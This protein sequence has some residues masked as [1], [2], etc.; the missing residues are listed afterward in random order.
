MKLIKAGFIVFISLIT[1]VACAST[2]NITIP[3]EIKQSP[4]IYVEGNMDQLLLSKKEQLQNIN[5]FKQQYFYP[6]TDKA[7]Q[8]LFC[9]V[10]GIGATCSSTKDLEVGTIAYY[11]NKRGYNQYYLPHIS[12]WLDSIAINM[13]L[14]NFPNIS[15]SSSLGCKGIMVNNAQVR[16]LPTNTP[17]YNDFT[18]AG[19][20]FPF[21]YIQLSDMWLGTPVQAVQM[22][23]DEKWI[24]VKGQGILGWVPSKTFAFVGSK[25]IRKWESSNFVVPIVQKQEIYINKQ[26]MITLYVGSMLP[27]KENYLIVPYK[28]INSTAKGK[29]V[30]LHGLSTE[31]WPL[32]PTPRDFSLQISALLNMPYGWG[33][34]GF[35][36]D[37]SGLMRRLFLS[38]GIWLPRATYWQTN[39]TGAKYSLYGKS[40]LERKDI[41]INGKGFIKPKPFLTL[42]SFGN[43]ENSTSHL[44]LYI[45]TSKYNNKDIAVM[46][47]A[48]W[49]I[50]IT[51]NGLTG[52]ALVAKS[53]ISPVGIGD[54]LADGFLEKGWNIE[55][56]W[57]KVGMNLTFIGNSNI[58][59]NMLTT[60]Y[61]MNNAL[62]DSNSVEAYIMDK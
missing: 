47:H 32:L 25:F 31:S 8:H 21:D 45:G 18:T 4:S 27:K 52:R 1:T 10:P 7:S 16:S 9:Y 23:K 55:S 22:T 43:S 35:N 58:N 12:T 41:L 29:R 19:E 38:F 15:C 57:N 11:K 17:F 51:N 46:F 56:L 30:S 5:Y 20:G 13:D 61:K 42:I 40:E 3:T 14:D 44:G 37:C 2:D 6:W 50:K 28:S 60:S 34:N 53:L 24:L 59:D 39:Y 26:N 49:G 36:S 62:N 54:S 48:P 33:G